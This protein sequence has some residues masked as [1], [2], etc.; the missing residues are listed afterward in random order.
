[1][2]SFFEGGET[3]VQD[4]SVSHSFQAKVSQYLRFE[5]RV[6]FRG[7]LAFNDHLAIDEKIDP[8]RECKNGSFVLDGAGHL[9]FDMQS[10]LSKLPGESLLVNGL[11]Q[12]RATKLPMN[13]NCA[14]NDFPGQF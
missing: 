4:Q 5:D 6:V 10:S 2:D 13:F 11:K 9:A 14:P 12:P 7:R 8:E 3:E 1:M